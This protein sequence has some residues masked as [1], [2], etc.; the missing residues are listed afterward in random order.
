MMSG[1]KHRIFRARVLLGGALLSSVAV[2][3]A[4]CAEAIDATGYA[5]VFALTCEQ[6]TRCYG[7]AFV[8]CASRL[9]AMATEERQEDWLKIVASR[10]CLDRC[11]QLPGCFDYEPI[12]SPLQSPVLENGALGPS[13][14]AIDDDCCGFSAGYAVCD[15]GQC[16]RPLGVPCADDAECCPNAGLCEEGTCGGVQCGGT[17]ELCLNDFQCCSGRCSDAGECEDTP[18]PPAGFACA[19]DADCCKLLCDPDTKRCVD[20]PEC[21]LEGE[22]CVNDGDCCNEGHEC[23][24][25]MNEGS[26]GV[27]SPEACIPDNVDCFTSDQC[28]SE[29]CMPPP[30]RLCGHCAEKGEPCAT[31]APCCD[32]AECTTGTCP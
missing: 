28:C 23:H 10:G 26:G 15:G 13:P 8:D 1:S 5:D 25:G 17:G 2:L 22:P 19:T 32:G 4:S 31:A 6:A 24:D 29:F 14:C 30:Y 27:C 12:C 18:C 3:A 11:D 21:S 16:C 20:P 9:G 7:D